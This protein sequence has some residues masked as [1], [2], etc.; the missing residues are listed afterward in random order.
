MF[1]EAEKEMS[2]LIFWVV[3]PCGQQLL[4][5]D[6][7]ASILWGARSNSCSLRISDFI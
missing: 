3:T 1:V 4:I 7:K 5:R 6:M 2:M